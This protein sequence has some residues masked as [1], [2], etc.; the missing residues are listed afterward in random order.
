MNNYIVAYAP[1]GRDPGCDYT[2]LYFMSWAAK[3]SHR[4][5]SWQLRLNGVLPISA[6]QFEGKPGFSVRYLHP[7]KKDKL[8]LASFVVSSGRV[9]KVGEE[10]IP[11]TRE[12]R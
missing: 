11:N 8:V 2:R 10:E 3:G 6:Y 4:V 12:I 1:I 7:S 5:D 9:R